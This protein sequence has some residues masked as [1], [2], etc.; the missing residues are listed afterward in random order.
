MKKFIIFPVILTILIFS[1]ELYGQFIEEVDP[2]VSQFPI[3]R[4]VGDPNYTGD[5]DLQI[6]LMTVP[7]RGGLNYDINLIYVMGNGVP[8]SQSAS[9]VGLGWNLNMY[10]ISCSP[11]YQYNTGDYPE[12]INSTGKDLYYLSY[13]GGFTPIMEFSGGDWLPL[14]WRKLKIEAIPAPTYSDGVYKDY[15]YFLLFYF[16][17][18]PY[19]FQLS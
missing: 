9:W 1:V 15:L 11:S 7:G 6:P 10:Q 13:P 2:T 18:L 3:L 14:Q 17:F 19:H 8:A 12:T 5:L 16:L 4:G